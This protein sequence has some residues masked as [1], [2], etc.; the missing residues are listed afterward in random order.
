MVKLSEIE[1]DED[2]VKRLEKYG[3]DVKD[4]LAEIIDRQIAKKVNWL[5]RNIC[6]KCGK[7]TEYNLTYPQTLLINKGVKT[8]EDYNICTCGEKD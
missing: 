2:L 3:Y 8:K 5:E 4:I 6:S 1:I 7:K